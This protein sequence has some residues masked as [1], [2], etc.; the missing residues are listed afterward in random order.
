MRSNRTRQLLSVRIRSRCLYPAVV[1][2]L[3]TGTRYSEIRL[4]QW[5]Q[6]NFID[7]FVTGGKTETAAGTGRV[8]PLNTTVF[9][10][11]IGLGGQIPLTANQ[12]STYFH[13]KSTERRGCQT[14]SAFARFCNLRY[15]PIT[16]SRE[17]EGGL[18]KIERASGRNTA[19]AGRYGDA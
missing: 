4:L 3:N 7:R 16:T 12:T 5:K 6:I 9:D 13:L 1:I 14:C 10:D 18:G 11:L 17:L 19:G 8:I 15:G 2:A